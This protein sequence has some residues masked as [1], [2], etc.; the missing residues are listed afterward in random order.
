MKRRR[1]LLLLAAAA[2]AGL[3]VV[4]ARPARRPAGFATPADCLDAYAAA[5]QAG[6]TAAYLSCL[7]EP[8]RSETTQRFADERDLAD[9]LRQQMKDVKGWTQRPQSQMAAAAEVDVDEVR[10]GGTRRARYRLERQGGGWLI[11][12]VGP[13]REVPGGVR[14]GTHVG[15]Q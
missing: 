12:A 8:L 2:A 3:A 4:L 15:E 1:L 5:G 10:P 9:W 14:Y 13:A 7:A 6:D 11:A